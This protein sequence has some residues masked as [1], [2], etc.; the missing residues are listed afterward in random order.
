[1]VKTQKPSAKSRGPRVKGQGLCV[2]GSEPW[3]QGQGPIVLGPVST[4]LSQESPSRMGLELRLKSQ[5]SIL[6]SQEPRVKIH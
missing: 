4:V 1:M 5:K 3:A 2:S 6:G